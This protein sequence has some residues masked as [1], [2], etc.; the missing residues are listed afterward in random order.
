MIR[1]TPTC[2]GDTRI[3]CPSLRTTFEDHLRCAHVQER[4]A[5]GGRGEK[6][7]ETR[8]VPSREPTRRAVRR[9]S[10]EAIGL[11]G[12]RPAARGLPGARVETGEMEREEGGECTEALTALMSAFPNALPVLQIDPTLN[13]DLPR[14]RADCAWLRVES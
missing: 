13:R 12:W 11:P 2:C 4:S 7:P 3:V 1:L 10:A 5:T 9:G 6:L 8:L 14:L